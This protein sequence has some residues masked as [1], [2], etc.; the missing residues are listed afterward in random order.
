MLGAAAY[1]LGVTIGVQSVVPGIIDFSDGGLRMR[2]KLKADCQHRDGLVFEW[3]ISEP[4]LDSGTIES[5]EVKRSKVIRRRSYITNQPIVV[6]QDT[7]SF[8]S[9]Q[10]RVTMSVL[11]R[12]II[13][14]KVSRNNL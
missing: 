8:S 6:N 10:L 5:S 7:M 1:F 9:Y 12:S 11:S 3:L 14:L 4:Q 13:S 2:F